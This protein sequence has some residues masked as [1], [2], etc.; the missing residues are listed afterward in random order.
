LDLDRHFGHEESRTK[1]LVFF[2]RLFSRPK[3]RQQETVG[4]FPH[5]GSSISSSCRQQ[6]IKLRDCREARLLLIF[7]PEGI[8]VHPARDVQYI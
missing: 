6:H 5:L 8:A 7:R 4:K 3:R 1:N 2:V